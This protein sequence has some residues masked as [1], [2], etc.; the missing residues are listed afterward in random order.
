[1]DTLRRNIASLAGELL[2]ERFGLTGLPAV[3]SRA[4]LAWC[5]AELGAFPEGSVRE[6][7]RSA[8][9]RRSITPS[10]LS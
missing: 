9:A 7:K 1:M 4:W 2:R 3:T 5:L 6:K 8:W 10:A